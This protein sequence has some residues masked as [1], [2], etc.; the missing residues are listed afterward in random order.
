MQMGRAMQVTAQRGRSATGS[1]ASPA[2]WS[3]K[4]LLT[5]T[6]HRSCRPLIYLYFSR[7]YTAA[8]E[9]REAR[10]PTSRPVIF[11]DPKIGPLARRTTGCGASAPA[12][13]GALLPS[14][15][16]ERKRTKGIPAPCSNRA[17]E[18]WLYG[19]SKE[20]RGAAQTRERSRCAISRAA[21]ALRASLPRR[22]AC[23]QRVAR[24]RLRARRGRRRRSDNS[25]RRAE[26]TRGS[27]GRGAAAAGRGRIQ[28]WTGTR[29]GTCGAAASTTIS[30]SP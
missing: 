8:A 2:R 9:R 24:S 1:L 30:N 10:R 23:R 22:G 19:G 21:P 26:Q 11:G 27:R 20:V 12:P 29:S 3:Q 13:V 5:R 17:A 16:G 6:R 25:P 14:F 28:P 15:F 4:L 7:C 18:R